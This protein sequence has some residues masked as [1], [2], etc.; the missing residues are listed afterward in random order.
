MDAQVQAAQNWLNTRYRSIKGYEVISADGIPGWATMYA[1]TKGLQHE[2]GIS[3]LSNNF[4]EGTASAYVSKINKLSSSSKYKNVIGLLQC[5]LWCKGYAAGATFGTWADATSSSVSTIRARLGVTSGT[6]VDVKLMRSLLTLDAYTMLSGGSAAVRQAQ[7][8]LNG[9]YSS[10]SGYRLVPCDGI[11]SRDVQFGFM[12]GIQYEIGI[13]DSAANGNFG[14]STQSGLRNQAN[15]G[16]GSADGAKKFVSLFQLALLFNGESVTRTGSFNSTL[17]ASVRKYQSFM[18]LEQTG[19]GDFDTWAALLVSTGNPDRPVRG[20]DTTTKVSKEMAAS[21]RTQGFDVILRY[22]TVAAKS[23]AR[24]ELDTLFSAGFR[25][26]PVMQNWNNAAEFFRE[27][28]GYEDGY[29]ASLRARQLGFTENTVIFVAVDY[30]AFGAEIQTRIRPYF[31]GFRNGLKASARPYRIG[32][33]ATRNVAAEVASMGLADAIWVSGMSTGYSGN[34][35]Y[36]MPRGWWYNQIKED[37]SQNIDRN[38]VSSSAA[39][40]TRADVSLSPAYSEEIWSAQFDVSKIQYVAAKVA[41]REALEPAEDV[42]S[43]H[44]LGFLMQ[45]YYDSAQ[46][47]KSFAAA[48]NAYL[49][50]LQNAPGDLGLAHSRVRGEIDSTFPDVTAVLANMPH[51]PAHMAA[52]AQGVLHWGDHAHS[53]LLG[54]GDLGGWALDLATFW[55]KY[56]AAGNPDIESFVSAHL[57]VKDDE[58]TFGESD[59]FGD[60]DGWLVGHATRGGLAADDAFRAVY[61]A[62]ARAEDRLAAFLN[63]RFGSRAVAVAAVKDVFRSASFTNFASVFAFV[64][65]KAFPTD[66]ELETFAASAVKQLYDKA[67]LG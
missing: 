20:V 31:V 14:P 6:D 55:G 10:H 3:A 64:D 33:Y 52:T 49:P 62:N 43:I 2:L 28:F 13:S 12:L 67:G 35:G 59:L 1:I 4:G 7:Q 26:S 61:V 40:A 8:W 60:A 41:S 56:R 25:V 29:A 37:K 51:D 21:L 18:L 38:A 5:A 30:D 9:R 23:I 46:V 19:R 54:K 22:L 24:G 66:S 15:V 63:A 36:P 47:G 58:N 65:F 48:F 45:R 42:A 16:P 11:Y 39:P 32:V 57:G 27:D 50:R 44:T 53:S 34:L 17:E